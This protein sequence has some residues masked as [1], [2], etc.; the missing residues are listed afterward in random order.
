[1]TSFRRSLT[2]VSATVV[3]SVGALAHAATPPSVPPGPSVIAQPGDS[4]QSIRSRMFPLETLRKANPGLDEMLHPGDV[5]RSPYVPVAALDREA[6]ARQAAEARLDDARARLVAMEKQRAA[7]EARAETLARGAR[8]VTWLRAAVVLLVLVAIALVVGLGFVLNATRSAR[9]NAVE[10]AL[11]HREL[12]SRYDGL[13][14]SLHDADVTL[15]RRLVSLLQL[16]GG[17]IVSDSEL[18]TSMGQVLSFTHDL[19]KKYEN[20]A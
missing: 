12:Q 15:Q 6:A 20:T 5:V 4:W 11:R 2:F 3:L 19:K 8:S 14:R 13:R 7:L 16:H 9:Q 1:M 10:I 18:R 17:K